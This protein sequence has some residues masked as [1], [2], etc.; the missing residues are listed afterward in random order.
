MWRFK[1]SR[2]KAKRNFLEAERHYSDVCLDIFEDDSREKLIAIEI[3]VE[4]FWKTFKE[5]SNDDDIK[6]A[7]RIEE[8]LFRHSYII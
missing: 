5:A 8:E 4:N 3:V 6:Q 7:F 1:S 2:I